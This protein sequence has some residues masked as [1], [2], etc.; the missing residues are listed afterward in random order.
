MGLNKKEILQKIKIHLGYDKDKD[1]ALYL[2]ISQNVL[3]NWKGRNTFDEN[4]LK[5]K[6]PELSNA[7]LLTGEGDMLAHGHSQGGS[8]NINISTEGQADY[9]KASI[10]NVVDNNKELRLRIK[11][12]EEQLKE[13]DKTIEDLKRDKEKLYEDV[14]FFKKMINK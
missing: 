8:G 10:S 4:L 3:S 14:Q 1:F 12:L 6:V 5:E 9:R 7:W 2:G 13:R 11:F